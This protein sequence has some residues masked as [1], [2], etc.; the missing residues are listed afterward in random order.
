[1]SRSTPLKFWR[2][3][4]SLIEIMLV[5][6]S[7]SVVV[8]GGIYAISQARQSS[9]EAKLRQDVQ[10]LNQAISVYMTNGGRLPDT[11][12]AQEVIR[13]MR[14]VAAKVRDT[15]GN[16]KKLQEMAGLTGQ[17]IDPRLAIRWQTQDEAAGGN[18]RAYWNDSDKRFY[19]M[20]SGTA[21]GIREF[22]LGDMPEPE[23]LITDGNGKVINPNE[24][25]RSS[26]QKLNTEGGWIWA[27][28]AQAAA[29]AP[30]P[31][32]TGTGT[33]GE[34]TTTGGSD[35]DPL[36]LL[37]PQ[38]DK[39]G[40]EY[41]LAQFPLS[42]TISDQNPAG[43]ADLMVMHSESGSWEKYLGPVSVEPG[44]S[45][46]AR[47]AA[48]DQDNF[49]DS[50]ETA[51]QTYTAVQVKPEL[52]VNFSR[53]AYDYREL[54]GAIAGGNTTP[55]AAPG[56]VTLVNPADVPAGR[57][58]SDSFRVYW[59]M[60]G[61]NP[62]DAA[63]PARVSGPV[64]SGTFPLHEIPLSVDQFTAAGLQVKVAAQAIDTAAFANSDVTTI[65]LGVNRL[66]LPGCSIS[67]GAGSVSLN[68]SSAGG[69][70]PENAR[71][72]YSTTGEDPGD[73]GNGGP[74]SSGALLYGGAFPAP[75]GMAQII[76]RTAAPAGK[77]FWFATSGPTYA[78]VGDPPAGTFYATSGSSPNLY[79]FDPAT[80]SNIIRSSET[81]FTPSAVAYIPQTDRVYY[82][83]AG[84]TGLAKYEPA[85]NSH[86][87][88]GALT[89]PGAMYAPAAAP[90]NLVAFNSNLYYVAEGSDDLI[91]V[92]LKPDGTVRQQF[93]YA[94]ITGD[95]TAF[96]GIGDTAVDSSG[97]LCISAS[98]AWAA[99]S[100]VDLTTWSVPVNSPAQVWAGLAF[101]SS[102]NLYGIKS[103]DSGVVIPVNK[104][105]GSPLAGQMALSPARTFDDCG[106]PLN[107]V[108]QNIASTHYAISAGQPVIYRL[109]LDTGRQYPLFA[110]L[111]SGAT[112]IS[113]DAA[114]GRL[115]VVGAES[116]D[117][118][119]Y[120]YD[121]A[122][123]ALTALG[124]LTGTA[125]VQASAWFEG[126]FYY[127][128]S[129]TDD[130]VKVTPGATSIASQIKVADINGDTSLGT[131]D[132]MSVGPSGLLHIAASDTMLF[133]RCDITNGGG[134]EVLRSGAGTGF[135]AITFSSAG[136]MHG[137]LASEA[138][139]IQTVDDTSGVASFKVN[140]IPAQSISDI[141]GVFSNGAAPVADNYFAVD[142]TS[143][144]IL[145]FET[146]TGRNT[147]LT[148]GAPWPLGALAYDSES[149]RLYYVRAGGFELGRY[150]IGSNTH[151]LLTALNA[152]GLSYTPAA[153][154]ANLTWF[155]GSLYYITPGTDD[156]VRVDLT[157]AG[158]IGEQW[159]EADLN[160]NAS[161]GDPGD[162]AVDSN[163]LLYISTSSQ[164]ARFDLKTLSG[165]TTLA[166]DP[167]GALQ[168]LYVVGG[169]SFFGTL[170]SAPRD[171]RAV[172]T[173]NGSAGATV[174]TSPPRVI[175]DAA[176]AQP[177]VNVTPPT[178]FNYATV[179]GVS[180]L[181]R[182]NLS[183]G[184]LQPVTAS[185]PV[186]PEAVAWDASENRVY[187]S[188]A[189]VTAGAP[190]RIFRFDPTTQQHS[191]V[192]D[193]HTASGYAIS[194]GPKN[195]LRLFGDLYTIQGDDDFVRIS[196][197]GSAAT[198]TKMADL[199]GNT[200]NFGTVGAVTLKADGT[201]FFASE[202]SNLLAKASIYAP[203]GYT[204]ISSTAVRN[205]SLAFSGTTLRG[206]HASTPAVI[207]TVDQLTG[208]RSSATPV[209]P[210]RS[211]LDIAGALALNPYLPDCYAVGGGNRTIWK[212][213][214][215]S[216]ANR[217]VT[218]NAPFDISALARSSTRNKLYYLENAATNWRLGSYDVAADSHSILA[219]LGSGSWKNIPAARPE[220]LFNWDGNLFFIAPNSDDLYQI[221]LNTAGTAVTA[222]GIVDDLSYYFAPNTFLNTGD[223][224][225]G[226]DGIANFSG[227]GG[228]NGYFNM[229]SHKGLVTFPP[230]TQNWAGM[231]ILG[232]TLFA[233][234]PD[235]TGRIYQVQRGIG[236]PSSPVDTFP[237]ITI[238]D[239][240]ADDF[241]RPASQANSLWVIAE[242]TGH[243][244]EFLN[245]NQINVVGRDWGE[246]KYYS[247]G[248]ATSFTGGSR[249]ESLAV[250]D[251]GK[252]YFV[253]NLP[254]VVDGV[255]YRKALFMLDTAALTWGS[256]PTPPV[257]TFVGDL[258]QALSAMGAVSTTAEQDDITGLAVGY[259]WKLH[260]LYNR[261]GSSTG[262]YLL[263]INSLAVDSGNS[264]VN[265]SVTGLLTGAGETV[266]NGQD[267]VFA[268][269]SLQ[270]LYITDAAD[271]EVYQVN[272][273]TG[274]ITSVFST[275]SAS[276]E[277]LASFNVSGELLAVNSDA[278]SPANEVRTVVSGGSN[279]TSRFNAATV[280]GGVLTDIEGSAFP[281][282]PL[283]LGNSVLP[284]VFAVDRSTKIYRIDPANGITWATSTTVIETADALFNADAVA[285]DAAAG[286]VFYSENSD[287][288]IRLAKYNPATRAHT[289]IGDLKTT[290]AYR[291]ST[292]PQHL[293]HWQGALYYVNNGT[294]D[295]VKV[296]L[297]AAAA[298]ITDQ[299]RYVTISAGASWTVTAAAMD[300]TGLLWFQEGSNLRSYNLRTRS[301]LSPALS[302][303]GVRQAMTQ[304]V[305]TG[306][307]YATPAGQPGSIAP[308]NLGTGSTGAGLETSPAVTLYDVAGGTTAPAAPSVSTTFYAVNSSEPTIYM[309]DPATGDNTGRYTDPYFT[310][311]A[312]VATS[313]D[314]NLIYYVEQGTPYRLAVYRVSDGFR[315]QIAPLQTSGA[316]T[317]WAQPKAM[318]WYNGSLYYTLENEALLRKIEMSPDGI[319]PI[320]QFTT[321][322][323]VGPSESG[324]VIGA[325]G[326]MAVD[327]QG[328]L[329]VSAA[330]RILKYHLPS[331]SGLTT[332][333]SAPAAFYT[334]LFIGANGTDLYGVSQAEPG[335][336]R[337]IDRAT[338]TGTVVSTFSP[339][340]TVEDTASP[341]AVV[342]YQQAAQRYFIT[343]ACNT[344]HR[345]DLET[346]ADF[347]VSFNVWDQATTWQPSAI[348][349][350]FGRNQLYL[351]GYT[352]GSDTAWVSLNLGAYNLT[353]G[354]FTDLGSIVA[355]PLAYKP[356]KAP[357][358]MVYA[359]DRLYY[360]NR[361]T[362]DLVE[363][364]LNA[365][366]TAIASQT[367][368][369]DIRSNVSLGSLDALTLGPDGRLYMSRSD[370]HL[371]ASIDFR[372]KSGFIAHRTSAEADHYG[373]TFSDSGVLHVIEA[374]QATKLQTLSSPGASPVFKANTRSGTGIWDITGLNSDSLPALSDAVW[375]VAKNTA[376]TGHEL[377]KFTNYATTP[378]MTSYGNLTYQS[379][380]SPV[381]FPVT[382]PV[383]ALT[384]TAGGMAY[385]VA[386]GD[387]VIDGSTY[388]RALFSINVATLAAGGPAQATLIGDLEPRLR[389][390]LGASGYLGASQPVTGL[391]IH[392]STGVLY[393]L[394]Q[395]GDV[396]VTDRLVRINALNV[397]AGNVMDIS[398]VGSLTGSPVS[399]N[400]GLDLAFTP[401]GQLYATDA[402]TGKL[403]LVDPADASVDAVHGVEWPA[404][405]SY[406]GLAINPANADI[407]A[408]DI[409]ADT[410]RRAVA[411][412]GNDVTLFNYSS[413]FSRTDVQAMSFASYGVTWNPTPPL[414]AYFAVNRT[415]SI[416]RVNPLSGATAV[417][418]AAA[419]FNADAVAYDGIAGVVYY[420]ENSDTTIRLAKYA[421]GAHTLIGDLKT[422]GTVIPATHPQH[423]IHYGDSLYYV[424]NGT[425]DIIRVRLDPTASSIV[426]Q[427]KFVT[428]ST[429][430]NWNVRAAALDNTGLLWFQEGTNLR[431]YDLLNRSGLTL[432]SSTVPAR[433]ALLFTRDTALGYGAAAAS[434]TSISP[435]SGTDGSA[436][437]P[438]A[439]V[440]SV[441][442][443]DMSGGHSAPASAFVDTTYYATDGTS[444]IYMV[445]P[446]TGARSLLTNSTIVGAI[447]G[448]AA[449]PTGQKI[450]YFGDAPYY[451]LC[452]YDRSTDT[453][454]AYYT[455]GS[456]NDYFGFGPNMFSM[457]WFN[458]RLWV[459]PNTYD[460]L[461]M[462]E[463]L[464]T[465]AMNILYFDNMAG[466]AYDLGSVGDVAVDSTGNMFISGA[467]GF[468]RYNLATFSGWTVLNSAPAWQ[469]SGLMTGADGTTLYGVRNTE[470]GKLYIVDKATGNGT[471]AV[472]FSPASSMTDLASPQQ[473]VAGNPATKRMVIVDACYTIEMMDMDTGAFSTMTNTQTHQ[474]TGIAHDHAGHRVYTLGYEPSSSA[475][476][477]FDLTLE[478]YDLAT[479]TN[480]RVGSLITDAPGY[481][482]TLPPGPGFFAG[483]K[484]YYI[485]PYTDDLVEISVNAAGTAITGVTKVADI[486]GNTSSLGK[487]DAMALH[488][489]GTLYIARSDADYLATY[490]F[491]QRTGLTVLKNTPAAK[492]NALGLHGGLLHALTPDA[493]RQ[494][495]T[496]TPPSWDAAFK[497]S[498]WG[499]VQD[500]AGLNT[501]TVTFQSRPLY[502]IARNAGQ[503][504]F[505]WVRFN[506]Y[507]T[508]GRTVTNFGD[509]FYFSSGSPVMFPSSGADLHALAVEGS[510]K[511]WFVANGDLTVNGS[512]VRRGLFTLNAASQTVGIPVV[513]D[514]LGDLEPRLRALLGSSTALTTQ[515]VTGL[516]IHPSSGT[517]YGLLQDGDGTVA[518]RLF[519]INAST[520]SGGNIGD[521][522][523]VGTLSG[524]AGSVTSAG[525]LTFSPDGTLLVSDTAAGKVFRV[526]PADA[527]VD[528][529]HSSGT[530]EGQYAALAANPQNGAV[531]GSAATAGSLRNVLAG[532]DNDADLF[533]YSSLYSLREIR[534]MNFATSAIT[535]NPTPETAYY[536]VTGSGTSIYSFTIP[537]A[538]TST[539]TAGCLFTPAAVAHDPERGFI[540]YTE[541]VPSGFRLARFSKAD[542]THLLIGSIDTAAPYYNPSIAPANLEFYGGSLYYIHD[543]SDD[544]VRI[545]LNAA[546]TSVAACVKVADIN[547]NS[548]TF[549][550]VGDLAIDRDG[551]LHFT[552]VNGL[553]TYDLVRL[554]GFA[555]KGGSNL[556]AAVFAEDG[557]TLYG[558]SSTAASS[559]FS[560]SRTTGAATNLTAFTP[561][562]TPVDFAGYPPAA[563]A[564]VA[565]SHYAVNSTRTLYR[566]DP[567]TGA[568]QAVNAAAPFNMGSVAFDSA[569]G[570]V[571]Y[572]ESG[573]AA[574]KLGSYNLATGVHTDLG[575][576]AESG[577][578]AVASG[579]E[580]G[581]LFVFNGTPHYIKPGTDDVVRVELNAAK[582]G[583]AFYTKHADI[584]ANTASFTSIGDVTDVNDAG[585]GFFTALRNDGAKVIA[586]YNMTTAG[587]YTALWSTTRTWNALLRVSADTLHGVPSDAA[588]SIFTGA[589]LTAAGPA[590]SG[591]MQFSDF[592]STSGGAV[593]PAATYFTT[594]SSPTIWTMAANAGGRLTGAAR[595]VTAA[596][597]FNVAGLAV[598]AASRM[599]YYTENA[600][601]SFR[602]GRYSLD[603]ATHTVLGSMMS[604][605]SYN[606]TTGSSHLIFFAGDLYYV[607]S[608]TD[609]LIRIDL[610][611][612]A[613][614][615]QEKVAD[616]TG[617]AVNFGT[618]RAAARDANGYM[619]IAYSAAPYF[620]RFNL[621]R[622]GGIQHVSANTLQLT[623][624]T[625]GTSG[626]AADP[627][628]PSY[629]TR[630]GVNPG[631]PA[632]LTLLPGADAGVTYPAQSSPVLTIE[633]F[634]TSEDNPDNI[635]E[636]LRYYATDGT[637]MIWRIDPVTGVNS[638]LV[639]N[640]DKMGMKPCAI[641]YDAAND[642]IYIGQMP[643]DGFRVALFRAAADEYAGSWDLQSAD[644]AYIPA[645]MPHSMVWYGGALW[646]VTPGTD[647]L[648]RTELGTGQSA[649]ASQ[650]KISDLTANASALTVKAMSLRDDGMLFLSSGTSF[651]SY[652]MRSQGP[653]TLLN[654][655][656]AQYETLLHTSLSALYGTRTG[657]A[658]VIDSV[659]QSTG[660]ATAGVTTAPV[661]QF[662]EM[663]GPNTAA[664]PSS[665]DYFAS[666]GNTKLFSIDP[667][668]LTTGSTTVAPTTELSPL[669]SF[670]ADSIAFD[671]VR[672]VIYYL[673][674]SDTNTRLGRYVLGATNTTSVMRNLM[675]QP[676]SATM[677]NI[678]VRPYNL[679]YYDGSLYFIR[680]E[681]GTTATLLANKDDLIKITLSP[682]GTSVVSMLKVADVSSALNVSGVDV[683]SATVDDTGMLWFSWGSTTTA[684][685]SKYNLRTL[686]GYQL[687]NNAMTQRNSLAWI[688]PAGSLFGAGYNTTA[689]VTMARTLYPV[690]S[691][692]VLGSPARTASISDVIRDMASGNFAPPPPSSTLA[693][694]YIAGEFYETATGNYRGIARLK[695]DGTLDTSFSPGG[696]NSG[697]KVR[698]LER[699]GDGK[700]LIGGDFTTVNGTSRAALARLNSDGSLDSSFAPVVSLDQS[701]TL[702]WGSVSIAENA[703]LSGA[704]TTAAAGSGSAGFGLASA[705]GFSGFG[706]Q[707]LSNVNGSGV[708]V[709]LR[710]SQ[711]MSPGGPRLYGPTGPLAS[712]LLAGPNPDARVTGPYGLVFTG[713]RSGT[714]TPATLGLDFSEPV[715]IDSVILGGVSTV[716]GKP[717][718]AL[719][720]AW[721]GAATG[722]SL[723]PASEFTNLSGSSGPLYGSASDPVTTNAAGNAILGS[724]ASGIYRVAGAGASEDSRFGRARFGWNT[725][726][727]QSLAVSSFGHLVSYADTSALA[728]A[729][730][731]SSWLNVPWSTTETGAGIFSADVT[732][733]SGLLQ[734][735]S[736][737]ATE[738]QDAAYVARFGN[739][740]SIPYFYMGPAAGTAM[741]LVYRFAAPV[742][743]FDLVVYDVDENDVVNLVAKDSSGSAITG[744][745]G[746]H[747]I[748]GDMT[749]ATLPA[750][751]IPAWNATTG[752]LT[753]AAA[754]LNQNRS[755]SVFR[756]AVP[757]TEIGITFTGGAAS[758]KHVYT[759]LHGCPSVNGMSQSV[760]AK[761]L[762][763]AQDFSIFTSGNFSMTS[764]GGSISKGVATGGNAVYTGLSIGNDLTSAADGTDQ[765][766]VNGSLTT[767]GNG[768]LNRGNAVYGSS[769]NASLIYVN[770]GGTKRVGSSSIFA[771]TWP[772]VLA[773]SADWA[774]MPTTSGASVN[775][776][777]NAGDGKTA[778]T[779]DASNLSGLVMVNMDASKFTSVSGMTIQ[780]VG[781]STVLVMNIPGATPPQWSG[782]GTTI[783]GTAVNPMKQIVYHFPSATT[784]S[785]NS[786]EVKG[787]VLAPSGTVYIGTGGGQFRGNVIAA[788][789]DLRSVGTFGGSEF[790][791][792]YANPAAGSATPVQMHLSKIVFRKQTSTPGKVWA[793]AAQADGKVVIGGEFNS[794]NGVARRNV[795]R[796]NAD[797]TLDT[798]FDPLYSGTGPD[799]AVWSLRTLP[800]GKVQVGGAF[801]TWHGSSAGAK[802]VTLNTDGSRDTA[803]SSP[804][805]VAATDTV[806]WLG[807]GGTSTWVGGKF[808]TPTNNVAL[809]NSSNGTANGSFAAGTGANGTVH[810][811]AL[812]SSAIVLAGE[813][814]SINGTARN[815]VAKVSEA[816]AVD[817]T[818]SSP[819]PNAAAEAV[820]S[821][822]GSW[823]HLGGRFST[824]GTGNTRQGVSALDGSTGTTV[825]GAWGLSGMTV[826]NIA[827]IK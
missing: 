567:A 741:T 609:D 337:L 68:A 646:Y 73:N 251:S 639:Y 60:D 718:A 735:G 417:E 731:S 808:S 71:L 267:L 182:I 768:A 560:I 253:R 129:G 432:I 813:F 391:A 307:F 535:W 300:N 709:K 665:Y 680:R 754:G 812:I 343:G 236:T 257:A 608:G 643:G 80:G 172:S 118:R 619:S 657:T 800:G 527:S 504:A 751:T 260:A 592:A 165:F 783:T 462:C 162:L 155:N 5:V 194:T 318:V 148:S 7:L 461:I 726:P 818:F 495:K 676:A 530:A 550:S 312:A 39:A 554:S 450:A 492:Y 656:A 708:N 428:M 345:I 87:S 17:M 187:Y 486:T 616:L 16:E 299:T 140:T 379:S 240:A 91:R 598:D 143:K 478:M 733:T 222:M 294:S 611:N 102:G 338:G 231:M 588:S 139:K 444:A 582:T 26:M 515:L 815:Y 563:T 696:V 137:V 322:S 31:R 497:V 234:K 780:N 679:V 489:D 544:L 241:A 678:G 655:S 431:R 414:P 401:S 607:Q 38:F 319:T 117:Y 53:N 313:A 790:T 634:A 167:A 434:I 553:H 623:A 382:A 200:A 360:V 661:R 147:V 794:V 470:P 184:A 662:L 138:Q 185:C 473:S 441:S 218:T 511:A 756:P 714:I 446:A 593:D 326:D 151:T 328:W 586:E 437:T 49:Y 508:A 760:V 580:P 821:S 617:N 633:E 575:R 398:L 746:W 96:T 459:V 647:D 406:A 626:F 421:A 519:R 412:D 645:R 22:Y 281:V 238:G 601:G 103:T 453:H 775:Y 413:L 667:A 158:N 629:V 115:Y 460:R 503:T 587:A 63:N 566:I 209:S 770:N 123:S 749:T 693:P 258:T 190:N 574:W 557:V 287:T 367:K 539:V 466:G 347:V 500:I 250:D 801:S 452:Y 769:P 93:K 142:G 483:G 422:A 67:Y 364:T 171:L 325:I 605:W 74:A 77:E 6:A 599:I 447:G 275:D 3:A 262:D 212:V 133:G 249:V 376:G 219:T 195:L 388:R 803:F 827:N 701:Y 361:D 590:V 763:A 764:G 596:A 621:R 199:S 156:L 579:S 528:A 36:Q 534:A 176:S 122:G 570:V 336:V 498:T 675:D 266:T 443:Y 475:P 121:L 690:S 365:G 98:N 23:A 149:A 457:T 440:P 448:L 29:T 273:K 514:F 507:D 793:I 64:F 740:T 174:A 438:V 804:L 198:L 684:K 94:D 767:D 663:T 217:P 456:I 211:I 529:V 610:N 270:T 51:I 252:A 538:V 429:G 331:T 378:A 484:I 600:S 491:T 614:A 54:G 748:S 327:S 400:L 297:D 316:E 75:A 672:R 520:V 341:N 264:L 333:S 193:L 132:A 104:A 787:S 791:G 112:S 673:E 354:G 141:T 753:S 642:G 97:M 183:T 298:A 389:A 216:G 555:T 747:Q 522:S 778:I 374:N 689:G 699:T 100:L 126:A 323:L 289:L 759:A 310:G 622:R 9:A 658:A 805:S 577:G 810:S 189:G 58:S 788:A 223:G 451:T 166:T 424:N 255:T 69:N 235:E 824:H 525:D 591:G 571:Y 716:N 295:V 35:K 86:S 480:R 107:D 811:G 348:A 120:R 602:L 630:F 114:G 771:S 152:A 186:A 33:G 146:A 205:T 342:P 128:P 752:A 168:S 628:Q 41:P 52:A 247:G 164:F 664:G 261:G 686:S 271:D 43:R 737:G 493:P 366:R 435:V 809:L 293:I 314:G 683:N 119:L 130:L 134:L 427:T 543:N 92:E 106:G 386:S 670:N 390:L 773:R 426:S 807:D 512:T 487:V 496:V 30:A 11:P 781:P 549:A 650:A 826:T 589:G 286:I 705:G 722:G 90:V 505:Q 175:A 248:V 695:P 244:G 445:D 509:L 743:D 110:G 516:A 823:L 206:T 108:A 638:P 308:L 523:L 278:G 32:G 671:P 81:L 72:F 786:I 344:I 239:L 819:A 572:T 720:R 724:P 405:A 558:A 204:L 796:L 415:T 282:G 419:L 436:G 371:L 332:I 145:R 620:S 113:H 565:G 70:L 776:A 782:F 320:N 356:V 157:P 46:M 135:A 311:I 681:T 433:E 736:W 256:T 730:T 407:I 627:A 269:S 111:P 301:S 230:Q 418:T 44:Q 727:V 170:T 349:H 573:A 802:L 214:P 178:G 430:A 304:I 552:T 654:S 615:Q 50:P 703:A 169:S 711:N 536:A 725:S 99:F 713:D 105:D 604:G 648:V 707:T 350:D 375:A 13:S 284:P 393:A 224:A 210:S 403:L 692:G 537:G 694:A 368:I 521:I 409:S 697:A 632:A 772:T 795:A 606:A 750:A 594:A 742:A 548:T 8:G 637:E 306:A 518:D 757:V 798:T 387:L 279:D 109:N 221:T 24:D 510:G 125:S 136:A 237:Q 564:M 197:S 631:N 28:D 259:D 191:L 501:D 12:D 399:V 474:P 25:D 177:R 762:G 220:N 704:E 57:M 47:A 556:K 583:V 160:A 449:D 232:G 559:L 373:L 766:I 317:A 653:L 698:G 613:V 296:Q 513:A 677:L 101:G 734:P 272:Y 469:W 380:G 196:V 439:T 377:V 384:V 369:A 745:N 351:I 651:Y 83:Q 291:P 263:R 659:N 131:V 454:T 246:L 20:S 755:Y 228:W 660:G 517:L 485:H 150:D 79:Q 362:D 595:L 370:A 245:W 797:G 274:A 603:T 192:T 494:V 89:F 765:W 226:S 144:L 254:T 385:F 532:S 359:N 477:Y 744:F 723:V 358:A 292:H 488:P 27:A 562:I 561:A 710:Y 576:G 472:N 363:I 612:G 649:P 585:K 463:F 423:L 243:L 233:S 65:T 578:W 687:V 14:R 715:L 502:A 179:S 425:S 641:A 785:F 758:G 18:L 303:G 584:F 394:V 547:S 644:L 738:A 268:A 352:G 416:Y 774:A 526:D 180:A 280:S 652:N 283:S 153:A 207:E 208:A 340:R 163:G 668:A 15:E 468:A 227:G 551:L 154:P 581:N 290:G 82:T 458:N 161:I 334:S 666:V 799:G 784:A 816:G 242:N 56:T 499:D 76:A 335:K 685:L 309:F 814:T 806:R 728:A 61:S 397:T 288:T 635:V 372:T 719:V 542:S 215:W 381:V 45:L 346:G 410:V 625:G 706:E 717:E 59:T 315:T 545:D 159:K 181:Y 442:L 822:G 173:V 618:V 640:A 124:S 339:V 825:T 471:A 329:Y 202:T 42:I 95:A 88:A 688:A 383:H 2:A 201:M 408:S 490:N 482:A 476:Y 420:L 467:N 789:V 277:A 669:A 396:G 732:M 353:T 34:G 541:N 188:E 568:V 739:S 116:G 761:P 702:D 213:N 465:G 624:L 792:S 78:G 411:G 21:A 40:G 700:V 10:R 203:R 84:G 674:N 533:S 540:Y 546:A 777:Y 569:G 636:S 721:S 820:F 455:L 479:G 324:G 1:M 524:S 285:Y 531:A 464:P 302:A 305:S 682:D 817:T 229:F 481:P 321:A 4:Y 395:A 729:S 597:P 265:V 37:A 62:L 19:V 506:N 404:G 276:F 55:R 225:V 330:S 85:T 127:I 779:V 392:P 691:S 402:N 712:S 48:L 355:A 357:L 66:P